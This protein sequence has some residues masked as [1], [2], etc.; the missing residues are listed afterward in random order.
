[1]P[2]KAESTAQRAD[3]QVVYVG[4]VTGGSSCSPFIDSASWRRTSLGCRVLVGLLSMVILKDDSR[5]FC[6]ILR[7][8]RMI[9]TYYPCSSA[10]RRTRLA[11]V[12]TAGIA[13]LHPGRGR[14]STSQDYTISV[15]AWQW[16]QV[17]GCIPQVAISLGIH[18]CS[19]AE[20]TFFGR[21][22]GRSGVVEREP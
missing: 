18:C 19:Q 9:T 21:Q 22:Q 7:S 17:K 16:Y 4:I 14:F 10:C 12:S 5:K 13:G 3:L 6:T 15:I 20:V 1:M 2:L 8:Q 11:S